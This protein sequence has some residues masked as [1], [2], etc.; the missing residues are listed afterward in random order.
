M[1][2]ST[3]FKLVIGFTYLMQFK[4]FLNSNLRYTP[5]IGAFILFLFSLFFQPTHD[6]DLDS[7]LYL[8][9]RLQDGRLIYIDDFETKL[10]LLQYLFSIPAYF[11][12]IGAW[13]IISF[14]TAL[15]LGFIATQLLIKD[16]TFKSKQLSL[17]SN[18]LSIF[19]TGLFVLLL[20]SLHRLFI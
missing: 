8:G 20:Y 16:L 4:D 7:F 6:W 2:S 15:S 5:I 18:H 12:G 14:L 13:R 1:C 11:G 17:K 10:P 3:N 19:M 9:S